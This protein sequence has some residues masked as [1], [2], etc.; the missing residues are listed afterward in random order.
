M[1]CCQ[2]QH[3]S[4]RHLIQ[5]SHITAICKQSAGRTVT[6]TVTSAQVQSPQRLVLRHAL[7]GLCADMRLNRALSQAEKLAML[8]WTDEEGRTALMWAA[9]KNHLHVAQLVSLPWSCS[10]KRTSLRCVALYWQ[11]GVLSCWF[12]QGKD[13]NWYQQLSC[14]VLMHTPSR[15]ISCSRYH[16]HCTNPH[17]WMHI[18][19]T[20]PLLLSLLTSTAP[21]RG[22]R[23]TCHRPK[24]SVRWFS[25]GRGHHRQA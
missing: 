14:P 8:N 20:L 19:D 21:R 15:H 3:M 5:N 25:P 6:V 17:N 4:D 12:N 22:C 24:A 1:L 13:I 23:H 10:L 2:L 11:L 16:T 7:Q 18:I 9:Q